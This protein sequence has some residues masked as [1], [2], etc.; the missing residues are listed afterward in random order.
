MEKFL[1]FSFNKTAKKIIEEQFRQKGFKTSNSPEFII[2]LGG[3]GTLL[4]AEHSFPELPKLFIKH[5][6]DCRNCAKHN[7]SKIIQ[8][9]KD[10][11]FAIKEEMKLEARVN[12]K[13]NMTAIALNEINIAA[14]NPMRA[15]RFEVSLNKNVLEE[16]LMGDGIIISTPYGSTAYYNSIARNTFP[17]GIGLAFSNCRKATKPQVLAEESEVMVKVL[18]DKGNL[19]ADNHSQIPL[20]AKD[21]VAIKKS[22]QKMKLILLSGLSK[23]VTENYY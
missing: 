7:F 16:N 13:N 22:A 17:K 6:T 10:N 5:E 4:Q 12:A 18:R 2:S 15:L 1:V 8:S 20:K 11:D 14:E 19:Y 23:K 21:T 3:D 9:I